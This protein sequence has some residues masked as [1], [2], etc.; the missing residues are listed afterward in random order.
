MGI[1]SGSSNLLQNGNYQTWSRGTQF[2][3]PNNHEQTV[4]GWVTNRDGDA[5]F[6]VSRDDSLPDGS[7][8]RI[9]V[10]E[11]ED[12]HI[13]DFYQPI[14]DPDAYRGQ[15]LT[16][17]VRLR[18]SKP[19]VC[20][21]IINDDSGTAV[22][23]PNQGTDW[24]TLTVKKEVG[25]GNLTYLNAALRIKAD[26]K[27]V[28]SIAKSMASLR[29]LNAV[30][31]LFSAPLRQLPSQYRAG[32]RN[33]NRSTG[34]ALD[35]LV[36]MLVLGSWLRIASPQNATSY[37]TQLSTIGLLLT[38]YLW[39]NSWE[40]YVV[41]YSLWFLFVF[42]VMHLFNKP[43]R[44]VILSGAYILSVYYFRRRFGSP[45]DSLL[46]VGTLQIQYMRGI[47]IVATDVDKQKSFGK[48]A[49]MFLSYVG[50]PV[51]VNSF[52]YV[53]YKD[54][55]SHVE[56][57]SSLAS[58]AER[59]GKMLERLLIIGLSIFLLVSLQGTIYGLVM[60]Y[61]SNN[62]IVLRLV[63]TVIALL[64]YWP[65]LNN[66]LFLG[67]DYIGSPGIELSNK[68]ILTT[69]PIDYWRRQQLGIATFFRE[70]VYENTWGGKDRSRYRNL[71]YTFTLIGLWH[72]LTLPWAIW[73]IL[74]GVIIMLNR[75]YRQNIRQFIVRPFTRLSVPYAYSILCWGLTILM[76]AVLQMIVE[77]HPLLLGY[78]RSL[79]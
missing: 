64:A 45:W 7:Y 73:G 43:V 24:E 69:S 2:V 79:T 49:L 35:I 25:S 68:P 72:G 10:T 65:L 71:F 51:N 76:L 57:F 58:T 29:G 8:V 60:R 42:I 67:A 14:A 27:P 23:K 41:V 53:R 15:Q 39:A 13:L 40:N 56:S 62:V 54:W 21:A 78:I 50:V 18:A 3:S 63:G 44:V 47:D 31:H 74:W 48:R 52:Y 9:A 5:R 59:A 70:Q 36:C 34:F 11:A 4:D 75:Y 12:T 1:L 46:Y 66:L 17:T 77:M 38:M 30:S 26:D 20:Q 32:Y 16:F 55:I 61:L 33:L 19:G 28:V 37:Q 6:T 22:S